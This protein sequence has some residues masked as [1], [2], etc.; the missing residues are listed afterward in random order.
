VLLVPSKIH[1][2]HFDE[3]ATAMTDFWARGTVAPTV[4]ALTA[5]VISSWRSD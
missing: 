3:P 2:D 1:E 4:V 5:L